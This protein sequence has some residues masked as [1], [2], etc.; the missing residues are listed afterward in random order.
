[1][2][3][4][5]DMGQRSK[6]F[7][8][9][10][11]L[12]IAGCTSD[13]HSKGPSAEATNT[14]TAETAASATPRTTASYEQRCSTAQLAVRRSSDPFS[15]PTGQRTLV[16]LIT[17]VSATGCYLMGYPRVAL[18][19]TAGQVLPLEYMNTGDQV[20]TLRAPTHVDVAPSAIAYV[21]INKYRCDAHALMDATLVRLI[22]PGET[23]VLET[24]ISY[25]PTMS[26]CGP[27]DPGSIVFVSPVGPSLSATLR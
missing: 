15:E 4:V 1:M 11:T 20:V 14:P 12:L 6:A 9:G 18:I 3:S 5:N 2:R 26:Y 17:N 16:L 10:A 7:V 21:T 8:L 23:A 25:Y 19:D 22:L 27:G 24:P 13:G